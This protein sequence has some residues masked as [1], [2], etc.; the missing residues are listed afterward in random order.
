[1]Q[2]LAGKLSARDMQDLALYYAQL[3]RPKNT[4][5]TDMGVV[6]PLVKTGDPMRNIAPCAACHGGMEQKL[7]T[8]WLEGMP[9]E[10]LA[11]QLAHFASGERRNDSH[12]QMRNMA[13]ALTAK[14]IEELAAFYARQAE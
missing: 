5:V 12:A 1:M 9:K 3:P 8:P 14:E 10:Y 2:A 7:G 13:R 11:Q 4:P 6:P